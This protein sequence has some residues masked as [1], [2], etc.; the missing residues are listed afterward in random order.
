MARHESYLSLGGRLVLIN[1]RLSNLMVYDILP[2]S[3]DI[4][5][6][7]FLFLSHNIRRALSMH[8]YIDAVV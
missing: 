2:P 6:N 1:S 3:Q 8:T 4:R 7:H 5:R